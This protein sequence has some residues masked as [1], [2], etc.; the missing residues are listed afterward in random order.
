[1]SEI[2]GTVKSRPLTHEYSEFREDM[3]TLAHLTDGYRVDNIPDEMK[4]EEDN[5]DLR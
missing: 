3:I 5:K 2:E 1:M 4:D